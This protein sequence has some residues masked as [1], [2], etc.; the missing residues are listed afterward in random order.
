MSPATVAEPKSK[1][2]GPRTEEGKKRSA[3]NAT[4]HGLTGRTVVMPYEDMEAYYAFCREL[5]ESLAPETPVE[6]QY[7][8]TFCDTQWR[9]NRALSIEDAMLSLGHFEAAGKIETDH[10]QVHAALTAARVFRDDSKSFANLSLYEQRLQR[11]LDKSLKQL[12]ALQAARREQSRA[13]QQPAATAPIAEPA[14]EQFV[15]STAAIKPEEPETAGPQPVPDPL[16]TSEESV[17]AS[18]TYPFTSPSSAESS[19][20]FWP[21]PVSRSLREP[22][23]PEGECAA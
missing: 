9:L 4:R 6:R 7:A 13:L 22:L 10:P 12:Q 3:M 20:R 8:Q 17:T 16:D 18:R 5:F 2:T 15:F 1:S 23:R 14:P 19:R 11:T 21:L